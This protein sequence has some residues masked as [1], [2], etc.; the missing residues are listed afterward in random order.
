ML[1]RR[2]RRRDDEENNDEA[3]LSGVEMKW[4]STV[5]SLSLSPP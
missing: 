1:Q 3:A 5:F 4:I 2:G